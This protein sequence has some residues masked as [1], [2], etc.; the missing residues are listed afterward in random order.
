HARSATSRVGQHKVAVIKVP[1][2]KT[3]NKLSYK[4][5]SSIKPR[6]A[7]SL[8]KHTV[9][10]SKNSRTIAKPSVKLTTKPVVTKSK[11]VLRTAKNN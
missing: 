9:I 6:Q 1:T 4:S 5:A 8:P 2:K 3:N 7:A 11:P 10:A